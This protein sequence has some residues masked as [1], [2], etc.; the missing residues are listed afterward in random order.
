[1][2]EDDE[3]V[4][5]NRLYYFTRLLLLQVHLWVWAVAATQW[6]SRDTTHT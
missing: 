1:M 5:P 4:D 2:L 3:A 6:S